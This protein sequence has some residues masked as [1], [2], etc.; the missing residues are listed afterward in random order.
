VKLPLFI[1]GGKAIIR[2]LNLFIDS[3]STNSDKRM[4][5]RQRRLW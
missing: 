5:N 1:E 2:K 3:I 4:I